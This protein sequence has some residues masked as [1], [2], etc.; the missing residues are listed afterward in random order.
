MGC[1]PAGLEV[2]SVHS[3]MNNLALG[4]VAGRTFQTCH[5]CL[6]GGHILATVAQ[7]FKIIR[8]C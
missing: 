2:L 3:V 4:P 5:I 8:I 6:V 1:F 7:N